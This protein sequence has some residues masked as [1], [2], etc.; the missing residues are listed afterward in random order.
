MEGVTVG[1]RFFA[2]DSTAIGLNDRKMSEDELLPLLE[3]F[4]DGKFSKLDW[5][6]LVI[7]VAFNV[8]KML[9]SVTRMLQNGNQIRDRGA[10]MIGEG[11]KVNSSLQGL[12]LVRLVFLI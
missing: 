5:L 3:A 12:H 2:F 8:T 7:S 6:I 9:L 11:L 4:R 1:G 10:E